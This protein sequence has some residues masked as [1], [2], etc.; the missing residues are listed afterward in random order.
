MKERRREK[1]IRL[2]FKVRIRDDKN[3]REEVITDISTGGVFVRTD[4][5]PPIGER[6]WV[7]FMDL[8]GGR[9]LS[10]PGTVVWSEESGDKSGVGVQFSDLEEDVSRR[11]SEFIRLQVE[12]VKNLRSDD[13]SE[14]EI[15]NVREE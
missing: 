12:K 1:R 6:I 2:E 11:L 4:S 10:V 5:P 9:P 7:T 14:E 3:F 15:T 13:D 8:G